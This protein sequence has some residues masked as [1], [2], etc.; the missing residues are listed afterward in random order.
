MVGGGNWSNQAQPNKVIQIIRQV[1]ILLDEIISQSFS[2]QELKQS[3]IPRILRCFQIFYQ[4]SEKE[5]SH[6]EWGGERH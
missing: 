3:K 2:L 1:D 5:V 4:N 6:H